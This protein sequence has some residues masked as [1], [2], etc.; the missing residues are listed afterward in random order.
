MSPGPEQS[1]CLALWDPF[2]TSLLCT[3]ATSDL[4]F[5]TWTLREG[6]FEGRGV[7][8]GCCMKQVTLILEGYSVCAP[9][10]SER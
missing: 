9:V 5:D 8:P 2:F 1:T 10:G 3:R 4:P 7:G 6:D